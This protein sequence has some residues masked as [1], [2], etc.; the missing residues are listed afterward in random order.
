MNIMEKDK[1]VELSGW[2]KERYE[3]IKREYFKK[4]L[5][6]NGLE[7]SKENIERA[8]YEFDF[9][10]ELRQVMNESNM[11]SLITDGNE[12]V[13]YGLNDNMIQLHFSKSDSIEFVVDTKGHIQTKLI[14]RD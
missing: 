3:K 4:Y 12:I 6:Q 2:E 7:A 13:S 14:K 9:P 5:L 1:I 11:L 8:E 10:E